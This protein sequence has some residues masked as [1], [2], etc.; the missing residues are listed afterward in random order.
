MFLQKEGFTRRKLQATAIQQDQFLREKCICDVTLF[1]S[2][3]FVYET[4]ADRRNAIRKYGYFL[5]GKPM[6]NHRLLMRGE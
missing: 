3:M 4:G 1:S 5:H 6:R 2:D